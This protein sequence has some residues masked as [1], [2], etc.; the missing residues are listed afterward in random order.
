MASSTYILKDINA[1]GKTQIV[2]SFSYNGQRIKISTK[3]SVDTEYW[4]FKTHKVIRTLQV[5]NFQ[6]INNSLHTIKQ[7]A[8]DI[9]NAFLSE[10]GREPNPEE[11]KRWFRKDLLKDTEIINKQQQLTFS[12]Y[13]D[14]FINV[15]Q[16]NRKVVKARIDIY[17]QTQRLLKDFEHDTNELIAFERFNEEFSIKFRRYLEETR[18]YSPATIEKHFKV[19]RAV[20]N[21]AYAKNYNVNKEYKSPD[22]M[23]EGEESFNIALTINEVEALY[24]FDFSYNKRL[25]K[26][27]DLF[28]IGCYTGLRFSDFKRLGKEHLQGRFLSIVPEKTKK[29]NPLPVI[30]PILEP[31]KEIFEKYN[32]RLPND[33]SNQKMNEYLKE[34]GEETKLFD[35]PVTYRKTRAG[36][37]ELISNPKYKEITTHTARRTYCTMSYRLGVPTQ[38]IMKIS[39]HKTEASFLRYLKVTNEEHAKRTLKIWEAYFET[40]KD[41]TGKT[42][43]L[44]AKIS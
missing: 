26:V 22:F 35:E 1:K 37:S 14:K 7:R 16:E 29:K 42:V 28:I 4:S 32:Y 9:Y 6:E 20:L 3:L 23:P 41:Q 12:D 38:S 5:S 33:I 10:F 11:L 18:G 30:I 8:H 25:E 21:N 27:K 31:V 34:M 19:I 40:A 13:F 36:K 44:H 15:R 17:R 43:Q 24:K 2:L 39:G